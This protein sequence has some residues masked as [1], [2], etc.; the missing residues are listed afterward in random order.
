MTSKIFRSTV[1]VAVIVLFCSLGIVMGVLYSHFTDVQIQQLKAELSLAVTGTEQYGNAFLENVE[2]D[3]FRITWIDTDGTVLFDT[4]ADQST[5]EN[6]ANR[7]EIREAFLIGT[8][9]AVR[10]SSTLTAQTFYEAQKLR[11]GTV[12]RISTKQESA[13]AL[14]IGMLWPV[15]L[16]A[17]MATVI[18]ALLARRMAKKIV[19][20]LNQLDLEQPLKNDVYEEISPLL[21][22]IHRQ[23]RQIRQQLEQLQRKADEFRQITSHMQEGLVLLDGT[24]N[25]LSIN[26]SAERLFETG[27]ESIGKNFLSIDRTSAM[28]NAVNDALD[29][30]SG[31]ARL[32]KNGRDFQV[33]I[34]RIL[35]DGA[36]IG[37]VILAFDITERLQAEQMRKEFSA[38]V[39]HE[40]KTPLQGIIGSAELLESGLAKPEDAPRFIGHIR[41]EASRLVNLIDDIIRLSQL[42]EGAP[43]PMEEVDLLALAT[44]VAGILEASAASKQ[45][46]LSVSGQGF[47]VLCVRRMLH[48]VIYNLCDNAIKY[49]VPGGTINIHVADKKLTVRD[50]GIGIPKEHQARVF[51]RFYRVDKSHS[52]ASGGTGLGLSIVKHAVMIHGGKI[53]LESAL[54]RGTTI[55]IRFPQI[56]KPIRRQ[57]HDLQRDPKRQRY[58]HLYHPGR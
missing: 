55:T 27:E 8:G 22:R 34:N 29:K 41:K 48:E 57:D 56:R 58:L 33:D 54:G 6:H 53:S 46:S 36:V 4:Q 40:L 50:T 47:S 35:S 20:P 30:G 13:W 52:K 38:N 15:I 23:R 42:D 19:E 49:N 44:D 26:P 31:Y 24:G 43:L 51:E 45:V 32:S 10:I 17:A 18:S 3:R 28:R 2:S 25:V 37:A 16:I 21:H 14:M 12:L 39:S 9:S 5:M 1:L 7:E 11:D